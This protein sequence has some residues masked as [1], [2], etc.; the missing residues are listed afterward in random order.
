MPLLIHRYLHLKSQHPAASR[1]LLGCQSRL[2]MVERIGFLMC[3]HTHLEITA[4]HARSVWF[5]KRSLSC[6]W[7]AGSCPL[8]TSP[9]VFLFKVADGDE[10]WAAAYSK[11]VLSWRPR[12]AA[13]GAVD[14]EDDQG[15]LPCALFEGPHVGVTVR[16]TSNYTVTL[17]SPVDTCRRTK[18]LLLS[19]LCACIMIYI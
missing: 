14:P 2:R 17:C 18:L 19:A 11:L 3:L 5:I 16:S 15:G 4:Q 1:T 6:K 8:K 13:S 10:A 7:G 12:H 9:V